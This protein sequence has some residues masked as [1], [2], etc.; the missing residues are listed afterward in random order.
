MNHRTLRWIVAAGAVGAAISAPLAPSAQAAE[1]PTV[2]RDVQKDVSVTIPPLAEC[3]SGAG[4][5]LDIVF[6]LNFHGVYTS[7]TYHQTLT[8]NGTF[9]SR[10]A[11]GDVIGSGRFTTQESDQGPGFPTQTLTLKTQA[12]GRTVDG[13]PIRVRLA[14]HATVTPS[15]ELVVLNV[16]DECD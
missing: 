1:R 13:D 6:H 3:P 11:T 12:T 5:A 16:V 15:G 14:T 7:S 10:S 4:E 8:Q 9:V 2:V